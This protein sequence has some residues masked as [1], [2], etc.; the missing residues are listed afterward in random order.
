MRRSGTGPPAELLAD[1]DNPNSRLPSA[2]SNRVELTEGATPGGDKYF[3]EVRAH[4]ESLVA[5]PLLKSGRIMAVDNI[6]PRPLKTFA[7][8]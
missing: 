8:S 1:R 6:L 4:D 7:S 3:E 2:L 5:V